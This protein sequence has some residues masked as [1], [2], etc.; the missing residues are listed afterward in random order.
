MSRV[1]TQRLRILQRRALYRLAP[2]TTSFEEEVTMTGAMRMTR[3]MSVKNEFEFTV[4]HV[5]RTVRVILIASVIV[6]SSS[7]L[8]VFG[9]SLY[10]ARR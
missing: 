4:N 5:Q 8:V 6:T 10:R 2:N 9:A 3:K 1:R 7:K